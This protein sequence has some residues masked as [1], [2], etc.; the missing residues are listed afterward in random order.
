MVTKLSCTSDKVKAIRT[1]DMFV[2][3]RTCSSKADSKLHECRAPRRSRRKWL[4]CARSII[5]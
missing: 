1:L 4:L 2:V 3:S 5:L